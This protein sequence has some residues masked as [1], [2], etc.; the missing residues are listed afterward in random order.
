[1]IKHLK[2]RSK[3]KIL[4][5]AITTKFHKKLVLFII[6]SPLFVIGI[7][8]S[9]LCFIIWSFILL[10]MIIW[11][12]TNDQLQRTESKEIFE[13]WWKVGFYPFIIYLKIA[14]KIKISGL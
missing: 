11:H 13:I 9:I 5:T 14:W 3:I 6:T 2:P 7:A 1:M 10:I 8:L 4:T 12:W